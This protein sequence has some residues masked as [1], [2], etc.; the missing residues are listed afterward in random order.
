MDTE[1]FVKELEEKYEVFGVDYFHLWESNLLVDA[2]NRF[3]KVLDKI[4]DIRLPVHVAFPEG[5]QPSLVYPELAW[6]MRKAG[7]AGFALPL[8][9]SDE[10]LYKTFHK[11][12]TIQHF[13]RS[14]KLFQDVG[15]EPRQMKIFILIG[16]PNQTIESIIKSNFKVLGMRC[17]SSNLRFTP[18]PGTEE[19]E[20]NK[21]FLKDKDLEDLHPALYP[22]ANPNMTVEDLSIVH[23]LSG[24]TSLYYLLDAGN[25][26]VSRIFRKI[27]K[28]HLFKKDHFGPDNNEQIQI[29]DNHSSFFDKNELRSV[30]EVAWKMKEAGKY[31]H[32]YKA[33][34]VCKFSDVKKNYR[35][36]ILIPTRC[37][38]CLKLFTEGCKYHDLADMT[39]A[40]INESIKRNHANITEKCKKCLYFRRGTCVVLCEQCDDKNEKRKKAL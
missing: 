19:Y 33:E 16:L 22:F 39:K 1:Q 7:V 12:G 38:Q 4:I 8:E 32:F 6:K 35:K 17:R 5:L 37:D 29:I 2:K 28:N 20:K 34:P 10:E 31:A 21:E 9:S 27:I 24:Y 26:N 3:E 30:L 18:I 36:R 15:F 25:N 11:P 13:D 40:E 14:V 23:E